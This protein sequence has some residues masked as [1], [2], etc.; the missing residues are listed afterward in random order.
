[1]GRPA[2]HRLRRLAPR[3]NTRTKRHRRAHAAK[4]QRTPALPRPRTPIFLCPRRR[5]NPR[6]RPPQPRPSSR[7]RPRNLPRPTASGH[8][9]KR[10][11]STFPRNQPTPKPRR[12]NHRLARFR[13]CLCGCPFGLSSRRDSAVVVALVVV[14]AFAVVPLVCHPVGICGCLCFLSPPNTLPS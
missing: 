2:R 8:Q 6:S 4:H 10:S 7:R 11:C 3:Q 5:T 1:M 12:Q 9:P 13:R 14:A